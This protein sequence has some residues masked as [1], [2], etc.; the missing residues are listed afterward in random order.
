MRVE[1]IISVIVPVYRAEAY[2]RRCLDSL[3]AQTFDNFEVIL[4]DDGSPDKCG[5]ICDDYAARDNRSRVI[6]Q[7]N[8]GVSVAR[9]AGIDTAHGAYTIPVDPDASAEHDMLTSL[10]GTAKQTNADTIACDFWT[11]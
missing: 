1:P 9:Q 3:V 4:V 10:C 8:C 2:I 5:E 7:N 6:H 11:N